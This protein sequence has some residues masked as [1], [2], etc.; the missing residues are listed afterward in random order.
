MEGF[1]IRPEQ[2]A[3]AEQLI[4]IEEAKKKPII[5]DDDCPELSDEMIR[6]LREAMPDK[7]KA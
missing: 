5:F 3:S 7:R 1:E 6:K 2:K 4:E